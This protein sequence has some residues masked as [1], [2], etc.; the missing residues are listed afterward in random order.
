MGEIHVKFRGVVL[1]PGIASL[2]FMASLILFISVSE[3][4]GMTTYY[5]DSAAGDDGNDGLHP[6]RAWRTLE[7]VN[8]WEFR[9]GDRILFKSGGYWTGVLKPKGSGAAGNP[10]IVDRYGEGSK[11][12]IDGA[13]TRGGVVVLHNQEYWELNN[14]EIMNDAP[15]PGD[16]RGIE[17]TASNYGVVHHIH[18]KNMTIHDVKGIIGHEMDAKRTAGIYIATL[19]DRKVPTRFDDI[20][21]DG[22]TIYNIEN[23]GIVTTNEISVNDYP[24]TEDWHKRKFTNVAIRNNTIYNISK[25]AMIVRLTEGGVVE[26]NVAFNTATAVTGNTFFSRSARGTVFQYNEGYLNQSPGRDG[27]MYDADLQSPETIW[28]YSYSHDNAHGLMWFC[29]DEKDTDIVVRYNIS[30]N[31]RGILLGVNYAFTSASIYNNVFY[32]DAK[33]SP[34]IIEES[35]RKHSYSFYN[36]II[37]NNSPSATYKLNNNTV[38]TFENNVFF[39]YHPESEP[40]DPFKL[41]SDPM[42][43][44][45]GSGGIGI[46]TLDGYKLLKGSPAIGSGRLIPDNGGKDFWNHPVSSTQAPNIGAYN[47][48]GEAAP[49]SSPVLLGAVPDNNRIRLKWSKVTNVAGYMIRYGTESGHY[50][51][52]VDAGN[53]NEF[54]VEGLTPGETY[55]FRVS[56]YKNKSEREFCEDVRSPRC[57]ISNELSATLTTS[58]AVTKDAYVRGGKYANENYGGDPELVVKRGTDPSYFRE[59][60]VSIDL[61]GEGIR[62]VKSAVLHFYVSSN[63]PASSLTVFGLSDAD[64]TESD[65]TWNNK[66][67]DPNRVELATIPINS[68]GLYSIDVTNYVKSRLPDGTVSFQF[69]DERALNKQVVISSKESGAPAYLAVI[70]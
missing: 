60:F 5:V 20:L 35:N 12:I 26:Y 52:V 25:N 54:A 41:T 23:Q 39:G 27:S 49:F 16:R 48:P 47:G 67:A 66:P 36:N 53:V 58:I 56:A 33:L 45:P 32:I 8:E 70:E 37:Y 31:D 22:N 38:R 28:Q 63:D 11:P 17:I 7:R 65:I 62:S 9:P 15:A 30:R 40:E 59:A 18:I 50:E 61:A 2:V 13:G 69:T 57:R 68:T 6:N 14:L 1:W 21:I 43:V 4:K 51:H 29:T 55:Y 3:A 46:H 44:A 64:W 42:L 24:G 34:T 10:I 19:D